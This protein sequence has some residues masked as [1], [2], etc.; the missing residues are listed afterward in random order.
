MPGIHLRQ[1]GFQH[2]GSESVTKNKDV[3]QKCKEK[4]HSVYIYQN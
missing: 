4:K 2:C 3:M 1:S